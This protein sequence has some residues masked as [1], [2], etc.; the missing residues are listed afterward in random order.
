MALKD[1]LDKDSLFSPFQATMVF[2]L[3][4]PLTLVGTHNLM[5]IFTAAVPP[6]H[7]RSNITMYHNRLPTDPC[8]RFVSFLTNDT[9][10][11]SDNDGWDYDLSV[12]T[13]TIINEWNL[14]C[15]REYMKEL[16]QSLYMAGVL[17]GAIVYG[18]LADRFGRRVVLL[19]CLLQIAT[20]GIG[21]SLSPNIMVYCIF[22]FMTG[23]GICGLI[24]NDLGLAMEWTPQ[25]FRPMVSM[26]Q[27]YC[28]SI[29]QTILAGVAYAL[30]DWR[31]L[32]LALSLPYFIFFILVWW[33]PES[34]RWLLL[35]K[36]THQALTNLNRVA[37]ING[38]KGDST[39]TLE[40]VKLEEQK[41]SPTRNNKLTPIDLFRTPAMRKITISLCMSWFSGS[42]CYFALA[43]DI[44]RFG[45]SIYL[46]QVVFGCTEIPLRVLSTATAAYIG[47]RFT[48]FSSLFLSG[49]FIL[50]SLAV[51]A[52]M[53]ILQMTFSILVRG[54]LGSYFVCG[55]LYTAELYPT[56]LR[57]TGMGFTNMMMRLGAVVSPLVTMTKAYMSF[58]PLLIFGVVSTVCSIPLLFLPETLNSPLLDTVEEVEKGN[59]KE[60]NN[61]T[62]KETQSVQNT[63]L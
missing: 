27:G 17:V 51:P 7:C 31:W 28:L 21:A 18:P 2:F 15:Q 45:L 20:M 44:Q 53:L 9:E 33:V 29:G 25:R 34:S 47:R 61:N 48:V 19:C 40:M 58:L 55:Y 35:K 8:T 43:M 57:Q 24:I 1:V 38:K 11:C 60:M 23:M 14:V 16:A 46:V 3:C 52:D 41:D 56:E 32:Q 12:Y 62:T 59:R 30:T 63:K 49:V 26:L 37:R 50:A 39:I 10:S 22:R 4:A 54:F 42:F 13:S 5:Q 6:H 36:R